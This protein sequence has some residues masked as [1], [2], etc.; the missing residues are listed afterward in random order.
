MSLSL[1]NLLRYNSGWCLIISKIFVILLPH[2]PSLSLIDLSWVKKNIF[3][4]CQKFDIWPVIKVTW[5]L[6]S[7]VKSGLII[8]LP[9]VCVCVCATLYIW[10]L[11]LDFGSRFSPSVIWHQ[12]VEF[13]SSSLV[14]STSHTEPSCLSYFVFLID[15]YVHIYMWVYTY[16]FMEPLIYIFLNLQLRDYAYFIDAG[17]P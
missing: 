15:T 12:Q 13:R 5:V 9:P 3:S 1:A 17:V 7:N 11:E 16:R 6:A 8:S 14:V 10:T 2:V 4:N